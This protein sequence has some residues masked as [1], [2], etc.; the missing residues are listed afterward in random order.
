M[1]LTPFLFGLYKLVKYL[2]YPLTWVLLLMTM[3]TVLLCLPSSPRRL[4]TRELGCQRVGPTADDFEP[5]CGPSPP[6]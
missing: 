1:E 4:D 5:A 6:R 3:T 2:L